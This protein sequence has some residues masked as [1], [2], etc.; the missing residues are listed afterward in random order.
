M[1]T[2]MA[3]CREFT[4]DG[5]DNGLVPAN[6]VEDE[7]DWHNLF[8]GQYSMGDIGLVRYTSI[9]NHHPIY[10]KDSKNFADGKTHHV[11][12]SL[13]LNDPTDRYGVLQFLGPSGPSLSPSQTRPSRAV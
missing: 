3:S 10:W 9:N 5:R 1:V 4:S 11:R 2:D 6:V 13:F 7:F 12:D 8:V